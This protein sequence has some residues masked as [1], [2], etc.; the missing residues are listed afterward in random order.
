MLPCRGECLTRANGEAPGWRNPRR[1]LG[2]NEN[3]RFFNENVGYDQSDNLFDHCAEDVKAL[4]AKELQRDWFDIRAEL[5]ADVI[6][7]HQLETFNGYPNPRALL[8]RYNVAQVQ[9][10]LFSAV[11]MDI[12]VA[13]LCDEYCGGEHCHVQNGAAAEAG[14]GGAGK[15]LSRRVLAGTCLNPKWARLPPR[16]RLR[17]IPCFSAAMTS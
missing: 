3:G 1:W 9:A 6:D 11:S 12:H 14:A 10:A 2:L 7:F 15:V 5:F 16:H 8:S 17:K 13:P 4:I